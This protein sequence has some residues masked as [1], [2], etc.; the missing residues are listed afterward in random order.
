MF[1][2]L[3]LEFAHKSLKAMKKGQEKMS[4]AEVEQ[5]VNEVKTEVDSK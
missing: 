3:P 2:R 1:C 4:R 5:T